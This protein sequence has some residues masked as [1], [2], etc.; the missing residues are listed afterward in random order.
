MATATQR[1][2]EADPSGVGD[3]SLGQKMLSAVSGSVLT[4]LLGMQYL[5]I[6]STYVFSTAFFLSRLNS[7]H[8]G[9]RIMEVDT[10]THKSHP[11]TSSAYDC[12]HK[13]P[14]RVQRHGHAGTMAQ[15]SLNSAICLRTSAYRLAVEKSSG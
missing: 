8:L 7:A 3:V 4:S 12:N 15:H 5:H 13:K 14:S 10:N 1:A 2:E 6:S 11:S 9:T